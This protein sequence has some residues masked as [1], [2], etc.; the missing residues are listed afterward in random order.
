MANP[1]SFKRP[2]K[3]SIAKS[4]GGN[5][6]SDKPPVSQSQVPKNNVSAQPIP[7]E[8]QPK[9]NSLPKF[10]K[11]KFDARLA[12]EKS[13]IPK[14]KGYAKSKRRRKKRSTNKNSKGA[15]PVIR[16]VKRFGAALG[17][18][19]GVGG[20][21]ANALDYQEL[22]RS[23]QNNTIALIR[24]NT[25][26]KFPKWLRIF[27]SVLI[28]MA[29]VFAVVTLV[30]NSP[31]MA[32]R[33][34]DVR[35]N[36]AVPTAEVQQHLSD[37]QGKPLAHVTK[38]DVLRR[39]ISLGPIQD[40]S[41]QAKP[42]HTLIVN[43][44]ERRESA[45]IQ[46]GNKFIVIDPNGVEIREI[47]KRTDAKL[48]VLDGGRAALNQ[49]NFKMISQVMNALPDDILSQVNTIAASSPTSVVLTLNNGAK[50]YWG[51]ATQSEFK[52]KVIRLLID[53][54]KD[55]GVKSFDVSTPERPVTQG[56]KP[57]AETVD[58]QP[59]DMPFSSNY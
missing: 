43:V 57:A 6:S 11:E 31:V 9:S 19:F 48:P 46:N 12:D 37:L 44:Q 35:N 7:A 41:V 30:V 32:I 27:L 1:D 13:R 33:N 18:R 5:S 28:P 21:K 3:P 51:D 26:D 42:P 20:K 54:N 24:E 25:V 39:L 52:A 29:L 49:D 50:V 8:A 45:M 22:E 17:A 23:E 4:L 34:I 2:P 56:G 15:A 47:A 10:N 36:K 38:N 40:V 55:T 14:P 59:T 58:P 53:K 16:D